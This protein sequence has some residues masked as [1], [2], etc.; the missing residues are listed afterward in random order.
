MNTNAI[1]DALI[2]NEGPLGF[3]S[4]KGSRGDTRLGSFCFLHCGVPYAHLH[5]AP[6]YR[7]AIDASSG[8]FG[9]HLN[10]GE[11]EAPVFWDH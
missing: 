11:I 9:N 3:V 2:G 6:I 8:S 10:T 7:F 4:Q 1:E 5:P